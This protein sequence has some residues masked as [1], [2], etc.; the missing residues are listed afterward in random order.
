MIGTHYERAL[1]STSTASGSISGFR[2]AT[3]MQVSQETQMSTEQTEGRSTRSL[4]AHG[5]D[6][7]LR[8]GRLFGS[9]HLV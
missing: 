3:K 9:S 1:S 4:L 2:S 8:A 5:S 6:R 7:R